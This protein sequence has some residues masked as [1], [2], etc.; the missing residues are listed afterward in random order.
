MCAWGSQSTPKA[1]PWAP[2][3]MLLWVPGS[4]GTWASAQGLVWLPWGLLASGMEIN[5]FHQT[6]RLLFSFG[7][8]LCLG[9]APDYLDHCCLD[10][11]T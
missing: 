10:Q 11:G 7:H 4:K 1:V 6:L 9:L 5:N 3:S 2:N 8:K